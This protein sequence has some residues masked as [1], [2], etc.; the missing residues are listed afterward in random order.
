M[1][2]Q[3][4]ILR[5]LSGF[6]FFHSYLAIS[7]EQASKEQLF[8]AA[9]KGR[10][11]QVK[12]LLKS[13]IKINTHDKYGWTALH[14]AI[15]ERQIKVIKYLIKYHANIESRD[16]YGRTPLHNAAFHG[17]EKTISLLLEAG[18]NSKARTYTLNQ[19]VLE[20]AESRETPYDI[21]SQWVL[22]M[23]KRWP[24]QVKEAHKKTTEL[25][26]GAIIAVKRGTAIGWLGRL[27]SD[28][29]LEL[30]K[31]FEPIKPKT[32]DVLPKIL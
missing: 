10:L 13:G 15:R 16:S 6:I 3:F 4:K 30:I 11:N 12:S 19:S 5:L 21:E 31:N 25:K 14:F 28:L 22:K 23:I 17:D 8:S 9:S 18:A 20:I 7:H 26:I 24:K 32:S 27:P 2:R 29:A 1:K